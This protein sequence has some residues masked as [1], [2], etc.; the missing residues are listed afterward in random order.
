MASD[1]TIPTAKAVFHCALCNNLAGTVE[2]LPSTHP[3]A[4]S[5]KSTFSIKDFIGHERVAISGDPRHVE[6]ALQNSDAGALYRIEKLWAPFYCPE[7]AR[8]YCV[9]HWKIVPVYDG[10]FFDCSH[11]Y[12]PEGHKRLIED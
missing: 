3:D 12:C 6:A 9:N 11:G 2:V 1:S 4:L 7:C 8:I 10:D 5:N